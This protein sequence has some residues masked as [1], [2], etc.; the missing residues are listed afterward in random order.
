MI[1]VKYCA[2]MLSWSCYTV[3]VIH[4]CQDLVAKQR[5][6]SEA[7]KAVIWKWFYFVEGSAVD[8]KQRRLLN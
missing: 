5:E 7:W 6:Y 3:I 8:Q 4:N 1:N 2:D